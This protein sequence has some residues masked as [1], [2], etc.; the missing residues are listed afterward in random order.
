[1]C[2]RDRSGG[3]GIYDTG[4]VYCACRSWSLDGDGDG[5][6]NLSG[7]PTTTCDGTRPAGLYPQGD[8]ND[9]NPA[10]HPGAF[11]GNCNAVD[12]DCDLTA[13]DDY[14]APIHSCGLGVCT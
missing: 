8:C 11:D 14:V 2:I 13:D 7:T 4:G 6:G 5:H 3:G 12:E 9:S 10:I 1:M